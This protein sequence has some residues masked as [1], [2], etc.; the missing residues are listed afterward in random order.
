MRRT[1]TTLTILGL[2][3]AFATHASAET[4]HSRT[5]RVEHSQM[6]T[7]EGVASVY[8]EV[9]DAAQLVCSESGTFA[10]R[11]SCANDAVTN[12]IRQAAIPELMAYHAA[13]TEMRLASVA[14]R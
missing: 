9:V 1:G 6:A 7:P 12:G 14:P 2:V 13:Q 10:S 4:T 5:I 3:L 11:R 8:A